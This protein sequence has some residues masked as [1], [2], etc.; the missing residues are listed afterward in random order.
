M[1]EAVSS[2]PS[3][4]ATADSDAVSDLRGGFGW[5]FGHF[6]SGRGDIGSHTLGRGLFHR[7]LV[8][9]LAHVCTVHMAFQNPNMPQASRS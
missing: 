5:S 3:S 4:V 2:S 9:L 6:D 7:C 1:S 8:R